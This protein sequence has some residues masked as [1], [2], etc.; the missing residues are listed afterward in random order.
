MDNIVNDAVHCPNCGASLISPGNWND[1][2]SAPQQQNQQPPQQAQPQY[3]PPQ[4]YQPAKPIKAMN[5]PTVKNVGMTEVLFLISGFLLVIAGFGNI[6]A[7]TSKYQYG[8]QYPILGI[9]ALL[10]GLFVLGAV[11]LPGLV[12]NMDNMEGLIILGIAV[13][14][15]FWGFAALY[16]NDVGWYGAQLIAA[17]LA[18]LAGSGLKLGYL[19]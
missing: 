8:V 15:F 11:I 1:K 10:A 17:G 6:S 7:L 16:A 19:K 18:A 12:K 3:Q 4:Q 2:P 14:F 9:I 13:L 5:M